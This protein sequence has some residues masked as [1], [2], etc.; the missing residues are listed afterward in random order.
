MNE[1]LLEVS[2]EHLSL[3]LFLIVV[4]VVSSGSELYGRCLETSG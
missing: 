1:L 2:Q 3:L 4:V